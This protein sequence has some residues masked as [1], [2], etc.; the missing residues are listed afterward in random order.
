MLNVDIT[1]ATKGEKVA[2]YPFNIVITDINGR[3]KGDN[4]ETLEFQTGPDGTFDGEIDVQGNKKLTVEINYKGI[5]YRSQAADVKKGVE[6][7][8]HPVTVYDI[9]DR[10]ETIAVTERIV[11]LVP[12][13]ERI[14]QVYE[15]LEVE[16]TGNTTYVGKFNDELDL[17]QV[18]HIPLPE[19]YVLTNLQGIPYSMTYTLSNALVTREDIK[20]GKHRVSLNYQVISDTG[21]FDLSLFSQ[22]DAPEIRYLSLYFTD[23]ESWKI[24]LSGLK[25]AG[26]QVMGN[27]TY[28]KWK[29]LTGSVV[30]IKV[31]G[32]V[33][34]Q[35]S[36]LWT[37][38]IVLLFCVTIA[39]LYLCRENIR[40]WYM[41]RE[42]DRLESM[43]ST[44]KEEA[45]ETGTGEFYKP[46]MRIISTRLKEIEQRTGS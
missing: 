9:S 7:L 42:R 44:V 10:K 15:H 34:K 40:L 3:G 25:P 39:T 27:K 2:G 22:N 11:T 31:Y 1:N 14:L 33:Y 20:P 30:H 45:G 29:G 5:Y 36:L 19:G 41:K 46:F 23:K 24:K 4:T 21:F 38:L 43:L 35:T 16:N 26:E 12:L 37:I 6:K 28:K 8:S 32:P 13:N 17:T 18:L